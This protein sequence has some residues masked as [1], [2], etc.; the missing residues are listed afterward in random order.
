MSDEGGL[1]NMDVEDEVED[2]G[3]PPVTVRHAVVTAV[4]DKDKEE[5]VAETLGLDDHFHAILS[6]AGDVV[7]VLCIS[8]SGTMM[9]SASTANGASP[10]FCSLVLNVF[11]GVDADHAGTW[12]I[13]R[14]R[15]KHWLVEARHSEML[16]S[17]VLNMKDDAPGEEER[18]VA[19]AIDAILAGDDDAYLV[20]YQ[21]SQNMLR[22]AS[23]NLNPPRY[24][25][26]FHLYDALC[27]HF[28]APTT[29][30]V[31]AAL[32]QIFQDDGD[33]TLATYQVVLAELE[34]EIKKPL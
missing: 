19:D 13:D 18:A 33:N 14:L 32:K 7:P 23:S 20:V 26:T 5:A 31:E 27:R 1:E 8:Y 9:A 22:S 17:T 24:C 10:L 34:A 15:L 12:E 3:G 21:D 6:L 4:V 25:P 2:E 11:G 16:I 29:T 30:T 28:R